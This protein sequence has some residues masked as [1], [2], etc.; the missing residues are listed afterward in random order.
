MAPKR[1]IR[2]RAFNKTIFFLH[3]L[4]FSNVFFENVDFML[5]NILC[6]YVNKCLATFCYE[7]ISC[8]IAIL[9]MMGSD[10]F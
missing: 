6:L 9:N 8:S 4:Y 10:L 2:Q 3:E 5:A 7:L 1:W